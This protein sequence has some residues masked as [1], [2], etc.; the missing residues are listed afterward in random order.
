MSKSKKVSTVSSVEI[1]DSA[2]DKSN[3]L[4][5]FF[6]VQKIMDGWKNILSGFGTK[7]DARSYSQV[8]WRRMTEADLENLYA[9]DEMAAK[10]VDMP[11][12][13]STQKGY[14]IIGISTEQ[15]KRLKT[16]AADLCVDDKIIEAWRYA[17]MMG[18]G[19]ILK[20]Y[21]NDLALDKPINPKLPI[22]G[23]V[24]LHKFQLHSYYQDINKDLFSANFGKPIWYTFVGTGDAV[25]VNLRIHHSRIVRLDGAFL[26]EKLRRSNGYW[27]DTVL[28]RP[29]DAIRNYAEAHDSISAALKDLSVAVFKI[30]GLADLVASDC[31]ATI[32]KRLE[33]VNMMKSM[34]R[35]VII[36]AEG[37]EFDYRARNLTGASDL[38]EKT[39]NRLV[40]ATNMP[41]TVLLGTS[42]KGGLGQT[43][44]HE[45]K[46]WYAYLESLQKNYLKPKLMEIYIAL[47]E[48]MGIPTEN[49][50]I[51]F[52]KVNQLS[53][54][55]EVDLRKVQAETDQ[56]YINN[57]VIDPQEVRDSRFGSDQYSIETKVDG[58]LPEIKNVPPEKQGF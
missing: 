56:T 19:A 58:D 8:N 45:S 22:T 40:A 30:N 52:E 36:D 50:D 16:R 54:K 6:G 20:L 34:A 41:H 3:F 25:Q 46:N 24:V 29:Y 37:E 44:N 55:E 4:V 28:S 12:E 15:E 14:K 17:R 9:G 10:I 42:P 18:G 1:M 27:G 5:N 11:I 2:S 47:C 32:V 57:G 48:E 38:V 51:E 21:G 33:L 53:E 23:F 43:G 26:P 7:N 31:D 39:E 35:A 13:E 49:L